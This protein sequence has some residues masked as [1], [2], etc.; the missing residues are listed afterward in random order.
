MQLLRSS[1]GLVLLHKCDVLFILQRLNKLIDAMRATLR[2]ILKNAVQE[3]T[4][5]ESRLNWIRSFQAQVGS[6]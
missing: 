1:R 2:H 3:Y 5:K 6:S 4:T